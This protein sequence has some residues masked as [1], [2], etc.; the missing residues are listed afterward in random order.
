MLSRAYTSSCG[1][2]KSESTN[3]DGPYHIYERDYITHMNQNIHIHIFPFLQQPLPYNTIG[4][5][6]ITHSSVKSRCHL[7]HTH[8]DASCHTYERVTSYEQGIYGWVIAHIQVKY[9]W[10]TSYEQGTYGW[11]IST[12]TS[13]I[14]TCCSAL[15]RV[16]VCCSVLQRVAVYCSVLQW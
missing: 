2:A 5:H 1:T 15:Q 14:W 16:A 7:E 8:L 9:E 10:V 4:E 3:M 6:T 13:Q 11:V 12:Y